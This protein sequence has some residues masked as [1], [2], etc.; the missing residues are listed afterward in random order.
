MSA[1][2]DRYGIAVAG[3]DSL[4]VR[5]VGEGGACGPQLVDQAC[6]PGWRGEPHS[7]V[8]FRVAAVGEEMATAARCGRIWSSRT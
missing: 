6:G 4:R 2:G 3:A 7:A 8:I 1:C 5:V